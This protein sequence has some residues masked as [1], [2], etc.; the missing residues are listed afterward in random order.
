M[1]V[2]TTTPIFLYV[3][4]FMRQ[5]ERQLNF[6]FLVILISMGFLQDCREP[7]DRHQIFV[8]FISCFPAIIIVLEEEPN[9]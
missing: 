4:L 1:L 6:V 5:A 2:N 7:P 8:L 9:S 3:P